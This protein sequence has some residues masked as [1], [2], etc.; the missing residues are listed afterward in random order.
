MSNHNI[1]KQN[2]ISTL[3]LKTTTSTKLKSETKN[4]RDIEITGIIKPMKNKN[5]RNN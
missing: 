4:N 5:G 2:T 3:T 1:E